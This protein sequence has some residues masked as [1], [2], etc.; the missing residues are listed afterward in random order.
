MANMKI[1]GEDQ[2]KAILS[3]PASP[4]QLLLDLTDDGLDNPVYVSLGEDGNL[5]YHETV[6]T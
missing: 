6:V 3:D 2:L 5:V 1:P 4:P